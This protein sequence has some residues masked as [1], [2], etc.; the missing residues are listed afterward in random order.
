MMNISLWK[1]QSHSPVST[2]KRRGA[3]VGWPLTVL[4][5][6]ARIED[7]QL[8]QTA[9][10]RNQWSVLGL[11]SGYSYR[12]SLA[13]KAVS[14]WSERLVMSLQKQRTMKSET[15]LLYTSLPLVSTAS[16]RTGYKRH[17]SSKQRGFMDFMLFNV[18][19]VST[20]TWVSSS[21]RE[22]PKVIIVTK[23]DDGRIY[24][25]RIIFSMTCPNTPLQLP[26][27]CLPWGR[28]PGGLILAFTDVLEP[29]QGCSWFAT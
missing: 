7:S 25:R 26:C 23:T 2:W 24:Q 17:S 22:V 6:L 13:W 9:Q 3:T 19:G 12:S 16:H 29:F 8:F 18:W 1:V 5:P 10:A 4:L 27:D 28:T 15:P 20:M 14:W 21:S 11:F